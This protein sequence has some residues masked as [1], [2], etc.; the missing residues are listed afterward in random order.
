MQGK[1]NMPTG[2]LVLEQ[3]NADI[4]GPNAH[5]R[6]AAGVVIGGS[7]ED[8]DADYAFA[9]RLLLIAEAMLHDISQHVLTLLAGAKG[10]ALKNT[11]QSSAN[12]RCRHRGYGS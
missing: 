5:D 6:I 12:C 1:F 4:G 9:E 2:E 8:L 7:T 3:L 10:S 11:V